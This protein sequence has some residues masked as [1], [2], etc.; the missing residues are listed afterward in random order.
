[1]ENTE[2]ID[3][4]L[5]NEDILDEEIIEEIIVVEKTKFEKD[6]GE[7]LAVRG[8]K[9]L[10]LN[11]ELNENSIVVD[12][13]GYFG[14]WAA[15]IFCKYC[16]KV[17]IFEPITEFYGL[18]LDKFSENK[19]VS[20]F[21]YG[22]S[23]KNSQKSISLLGDATSIHRESDKQETV[24]FVEASNVFDYVK[25]DI[26]DLMKINIEGDEYDVLQNLINTGKIKQIKNI[27]VQFH[28]QDS[29]LDRREEIVEQLKNT[30]EE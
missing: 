20:A 10:R 19:N 2:N 30:Q 7:W 22:L 25:S 1:M 12:V 15:S 4:F 28:F 26:I 5:E 18:I 24:D 27:Q 23:D 16:S 11:Y 21:R 6:L 13:G 14:E 9:T 3:D 29:Q 8:D 17:F